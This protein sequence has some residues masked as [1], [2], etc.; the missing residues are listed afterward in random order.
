MKNS[1]LLA[2]NQWFCKPFVRH[3][4]K[5]IESPSMQYIEMLWR[6]EY[7]DREKYELIKPMYCKWSWKYCRWCYAF[8]VSLLINLD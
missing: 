2:V 3:G 4:Y 1:K 5:I 8:N 6:I 7:M